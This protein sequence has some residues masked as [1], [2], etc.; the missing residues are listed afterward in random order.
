VNVRKRNLSS[1]QMLFQVSAFS[2]AK[3]SLVAAAR[4]RDGF[5]MFSKEDGNFI[6]YSLADIDCAMDVIGRFV[7]ID[8]PGCD[9]DVVARVSVSEFDPRASPLRKTDTRWHGS[10]CHV[11]LTPGARRKRRTSV[12]PRRW[13]ISSATVWIPLGIE[14]IR[15]W[16]RNQC[17]AVYILIREV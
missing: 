12:V 6:V 8:L 11:V 1:E 15:T 9:F 4:L 10:R 3:L 13:R 7:P 16:P 2:A 17:P 5:G 14:L